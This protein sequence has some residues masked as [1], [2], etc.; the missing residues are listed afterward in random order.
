MKKLK[1]ISDANYLLNAIDLE[2][3]ILEKATQIAER[4]LLAATR[5][6]NKQEVKT[7]TLPDFNLD[8]DTLAAK[9]AEK[10][11]GRLSFETSS[12]GENKV[13]SFKEPDL[14]VIHSNEE[15]IKGLTIEKKQSKQST[16][17]SLDALEQLEI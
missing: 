1:R 11:G 16:K 10:I 12:G 6:K 8:L 4:L 15:K 2:E 5:E 17:K 9:I 13:F 7:M 3:A 14:H